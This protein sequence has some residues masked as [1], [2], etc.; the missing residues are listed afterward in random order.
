MV[1][2]IMMAGLFLPR[3]GRAHTPGL[4]VAEFE[5]TPAGTVDARLTFATAEPL[6]PAAHALRDADLR[7]FVLDGVDVTADG[8]RCEARYDGASV[9]E[10]DGLLLQATY[11]CP[12]GA[13]AVGVTLYYLSALPR[14]H[15]EIARI[16]GPPGSGASIEAALSGD[17]RALELRIPPGPE[18][19]AIRAHKERVARRVTVLTAV[20]TAFMLSLFVWRWRATRRRPGAQG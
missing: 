17:R 3:L 16:V 18:D 4:S 7:T 1:L 6:G 19:A 14:G 12:A 13:A 2:A 5:V 8:A 11:D 10:G 9:T 20:F 15:R